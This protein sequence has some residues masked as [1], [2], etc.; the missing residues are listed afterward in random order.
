M[1]YPQQLNNLTL[2]KMEDLIFYFVCFLTVWETVVIFSVPEDDEQLE[3]VQQSPVGVDELS[4]SLREV[5]KVVG[6]V[7]CFICAIVP[8]W[9]MIHFNVP[10]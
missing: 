6:F 2:N 8:D 5:G 4:D 1:S 10:R 9:I 7:F 3:L